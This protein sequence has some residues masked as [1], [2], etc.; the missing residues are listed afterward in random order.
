M[1]DLIDDYMDYK[2]K[3]YNQCVACGIDMRCINY[4]KYVCESCLSLLKDHKKE[5]R[6]E[7]NHKRISKM[8]DNNEILIFDEK[9]KTEFDSSD[10][11]V[12]INGPFIEIWL[13]R[14]ES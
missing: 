2:N 6:I 5:K 11:G 12:N 1:N 4:G 13:D 7:K 3:K 14:G 9:T 10:I 8:I